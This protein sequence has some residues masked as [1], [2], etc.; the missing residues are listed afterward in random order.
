M[1]RNVLLGAVFAFFAAVTGVKLIRAIK[2][3]IAVK[4]G[5]TVKCTAEIT[6][7]NLPGKA[8]RSAEAKYTLDGREYTGQMV[9]A[10]NVKVSVG[11]NVAVIVSPD[12]PE[13]FALYEKQ[14]RI[15]VVM[16]S[17]AA[18]AL[19]AILGIFVWALLISR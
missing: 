14:P 10:E 2:L 3:L 7:V 11:Q 12:A 9:C 17:I 19:C 4:R 16:Y 18:G 5:K 15:A 6:G 1:L 8:R 13:V